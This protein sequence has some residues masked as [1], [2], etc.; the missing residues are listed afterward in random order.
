MPVSIVGHMLWRTTASLA[1]IAS[2]A[3]NIATE[4]GCWIH[5]GQDVRCGHVRY[6]VM[7]LTPKL[8]VLDIIQWETPCEDGFDLD[9]DLSLLRNTAKSRT[10][11]AQLSSQAHF[12][13]DH[14]RVSSD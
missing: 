2:C 13:K 5:G 1:T 10:F 9:L 4:S 12:I 6:L 14:Y 3:R 11:I 7:C 8:G